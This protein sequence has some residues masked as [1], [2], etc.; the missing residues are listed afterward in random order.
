[1]EDFLSIEN[2]QLISTYLI[3][4]SQKKFNIKINLSKYDDKIYMLME[5]IHDKYKTTLSKTKGNMI[6]IKNILDTIR[7][8]AFKLN[9]EK[10]K[11]ITMNELI[12]NENK[13]RENIKKVNIEQIPVP[14]SH[15]INQKI[16]RQLETRQIYDTIRIENDID[17]VKMYKQLNIE[18]QKFYK[19]VDMTA[20]RQYK[21]DNIIKK[22]KKYS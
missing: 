14:I 19:P 1:M 12:Q 7:E 8:D 11:Q 13:K 10:E 3:N 2:Y 6:I 15:E 17:P 20:P 4:F 16:T 18:K 22:P 21:V 5:Q 9:F